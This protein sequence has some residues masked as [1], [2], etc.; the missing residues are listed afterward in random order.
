MDI[1]KTLGADFLPSVFFYFHLLVVAF[2]H[3]EIRWLVRSYFYPSFRS[4]RIY[5][6]SKKL[7]LIK[8]V[9][10]ILISWIYFDGT[11]GA[12]SLK[13]GETVWGL[14]LFNVF[15]FS[16]GCQDSSEEFKEGNVQKNLDL[17]FFEEKSKG[18]VNNW[19]G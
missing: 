6:T 16:S 14:E 4:R 10:F 15:W 1:R 19:K 13:C 5:H 9:K 2:N 8:I 3:D 12:L 7:E 17:R 11:G 18:K